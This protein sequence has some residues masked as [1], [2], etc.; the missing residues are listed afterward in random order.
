[1]LGIAGWLLGCAGVA[2]AGNGAVIADKP[3][4]LILITIDT[5]RADRL[6][7]Y[8]YRRA[9]SPNL[10]RFMSRGTRFE[11]AFSSASYTAPSHIS[12]LTGL[13]PS[14][15]SVMLDNGRFFKLS[16]KTVTLAEQCRDA[17][18]RTA[19]VISNPTLN[20]RLGLHQG[21]AL[22]VDL[23]FDRVHERYLPKE[24]T[25]T[26]QEAL[27]IL[28]QVHDAPFFLWVHYQDPHGPYSPPCDLTTFAEAAPPPE[29]D[30]IL[31][32]GADTSGYK[33]IPTYQVIEEERAAWRYGLRYDNEILYLDRHI[34]TLFD[35][36]DELGLTRNTVI[37]LTSDHGEAFSEDEFFFAHSHSVGLDQVRVPL[38]IVGPG[39]PAGKVMTTPIGGVDV[40]ATM[41]EMIGLK[42]VEK[43]SGRSWAAAVR[44]GKEPEEKPVFCEG[45]SQR[46]V[47][48]RGMYYRE[49]RR[50]AD[51][52]I[53]KISPTTNGKHL[54]LGPSLVRLSDGAGIEASKGALLRAELDAFTLAAE[55]AIRETFDEL[56]RRGKD[57]RT[58]AENNGLVFFRDELGYEF[59]LRDL[60]PAS[61]EEL[62]PEDRAQRRAMS[63]LGYLEKA[64]EEE[65]A[66]KP[67]P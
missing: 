39:V 56:V 41:T 45:F 31:P 60:E 51:S 5:L 64:P 61:P 49:D 27:E 33:A 3:V 28:N 9:T 21:F 15:N 25:A 20:R 35:R 26:T 23:Q 8:G 18:M 63:S 52:P 44:A 46:G 10:D 59:D 65:P 48:F 2:S 22:Y 62:S 55:Q 67:K 47:A 30:R 19:A 37:V 38:A 43:T 32:V 50:P 17:G 57:E 6:G 16:G 29:K 1:M 34:Q 36:V 13:Y 7:C 53:W 54:P 14:F 66:D 24:A 11:W 12:L 58:V 40:Y 4:N 42:P